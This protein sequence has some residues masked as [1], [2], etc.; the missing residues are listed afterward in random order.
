MI[1][2][3]RVWYMTFNVTHADDRSVR[4][5]RAMFHNSK[6][7]ISYSIGLTLGLVLL[8]AVVACGE[9]TPPPTATPLSPIAALAT[10]T[11]YAAP[12]APP[13]ATPTAAQAPTVA[14]TVTPR[15]TPL[16]PMAPTA[17][18]TPT[19]TPMPGPSGCPEEPGP[20]WWIPEPR[21]VPAVS[22]LPYKTPSLESLIFESEFVVRASLASV[23]TRTASIDLHDIWIPGYTMLPDQK[24][25]APLCVATLELHFEVVEYLKGTGPAELTVEIPM[26][27]TYLDDDRLLRLFHLEEEA[28]LNAAEWWSWR[29]PLWDDRLAVLFLKRDEHEIV[30]LTFTDRGRGYGRYYVES[31]QEY[32][33]SWLPSVEE[34]F[35][36]P[37]ATFGRLWWLEQE[38]GDNVPLTG[39]GS[40][41]RFVS[42]SGPSREGPAPVV[43]SLADLRSRLAEFS[44]LLEKGKDNPDYERCIDLVLGHEAD[45]RRSQEPLRPYRV[46]SAMPSGLPSGTAVDRINHFG[47]EVLPFEFGGGVLAFENT[48][49]EGP[50]ADVFEL[51]KFDEHDIE[52]DGYFELLTALRPLP[53][54]EYRV[55]R[56]YDQPVVRLCSDFKPNGFVLAQY[57]KWA[58]SVEA[59]IEGTVHEAFFDP[60]ALG[61]GSGY[62][63]E[64]G[65][66]RPV[67]IPTGRLHTSING[68][69]WRQGTISMS[70]E[71]YTPL[72]SYDI[73]IVDLDGSVRLTL[74]AAEASIDRDAGRLNWRVP[75]QPWRA[76]DTLML[77]IRSEGPAPATPGPRPWVPE[78]LDLTATAGTSSRDGSVVPKMTLEWTESDAVGTFVF[79]HGQVQ[80]WDGSTGEWREPHE[81][82]AGITG[83]GSGD[84]YTSEAL[85]GIRPGPYTIRVRY[86]ESLLTRDDYLAD[87]FVSK[88]KYVRAEV[89]GEP[90]D[91]EATPTP[92]PV[93]PAE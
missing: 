89:P 46:E 29:S 16:P 61:N 68:L 8:L 53:F 62:S 48:W 74:P 69:I 21:P 86:T 64:G 80:L 79:N 45:A 35:V 43:I 26:S 65:S 19:T 56:Y 10:P 88:W 92:E 5:G 84:T 78:V 17:T 25:P 36:P 82:N 63:E 85:Y 76:G 47:A 71:P 51:V 3:G 83:T 58:I 40:A 60:A 87:Y 28:R 93:I 31:P 11:P 37:P 44:A 66:L 24:T 39:D 38:Y 1:R 70:L 32:E 90:A 54:G 72:A 23:S 50:D 57:E 42:E 15:A 67:A 12:S 7:R 81:A 77:R 6:R 14:A 20:N 18:P 52:G 33:R 55:D 13:T 73:D 22:R 91:P 2:E 4:K 59:S 27:D 30:D 49:L 34:D 75:S 41:P 9:S